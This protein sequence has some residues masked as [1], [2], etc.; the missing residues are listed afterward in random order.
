MRRLIVL[1]PQPQHRHHS[2]F[3]EELDVDLVPRHRVDD[4][5]VLEALLGADDRLAL[6]VAGRERGA[7]DLVRVAV[8]QEPPLH[9]AGDGHRHGELED[10]GNVADRHVL[11][12]PVVEVPANV[13]VVANILEIQVRAL[14]LQLEPD[15]LLRRVVGAERDLILGV[16]PQGSRVGEVR[17]PIVGVRAHRP[18]LRRPPGRH[19]LLPEPL[20]V[21]LGVVVLPP[22]DRVADGASVAEG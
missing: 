1:V 21:R 10:S 3:A 4:P 2:S 11:R 12:A 8:P 7:D 19:L 17:L 16:V 5:L 9:G 20:D 22:E 15:G 6:L 13:E 14:L 18:D